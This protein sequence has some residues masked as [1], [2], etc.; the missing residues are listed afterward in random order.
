MMKNFTKLL[1]KT[2]IFSF[3]LSKTQIIK[4]FYKSLQKERKVLNKKIH[5]TKKC[6]KISLKD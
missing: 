4:R 6:K 3:L 1:V 2:A 5:Y